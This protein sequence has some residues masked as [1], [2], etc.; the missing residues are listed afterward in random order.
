M[1]SDTSISGEVPVALRRIVTGHD[2]SGTSTVALDSP[3]PRSEAYR[4]I[5][6]MVSR[7]VGLATRHR[8]YSMSG[9]S[10]SRETIAQPCTLVP[11]VPPNPATA[12]IPAVSRE[13]A[14]Q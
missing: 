11:G 14:A 10:P 2:T 9:F 5:P 12:H 8:A 3:P 4:H 1:A 13:A 7:L 6:G